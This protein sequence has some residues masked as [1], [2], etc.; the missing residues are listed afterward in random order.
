MMLLLSVVVREA[1]RTDYCCGRVLSKQIPQRRNFGETPPLRSHVAIIY[2]SRVTN[3][4]G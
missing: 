2:L 3:D 4:L 1:G